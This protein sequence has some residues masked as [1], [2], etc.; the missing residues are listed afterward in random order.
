MPET[1]EPELKKPSKMSV[2]ETFND[3]AEL[4]VSIELE[5]L[6]LEEACQDKQVDESETPKLMPQIP[7][8]ALDMSLAGDLYKIRAQDEDKEM[9]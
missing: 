1:K 7:V 8:C 9:C 4:G 5:H 3:E 2:S 6:P